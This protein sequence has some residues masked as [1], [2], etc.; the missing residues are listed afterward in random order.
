MKRQAMVKKKSFFS[1]RRMKVSYKCNNLLTKASIWSLGDTNIRAFRH[2][3]V[4]T[5]TSKS[6]NI[7]RSPFDFTSTSTKSAGFRFNCSF[8]AAHD[9]ITSAV[10]ISGKRSVQYVWSAQYTRNITVNNIQINK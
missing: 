10:V 2:N 4:A 9:L 6:L 7:V 5:L 3:A 8:S 1:S